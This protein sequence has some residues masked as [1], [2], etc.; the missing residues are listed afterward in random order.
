[1]EKEF[2]D[3]LVEEAGRHFDDIANCIINRGF[4]KKNAG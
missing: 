1:M 2:D 4:A 3:N